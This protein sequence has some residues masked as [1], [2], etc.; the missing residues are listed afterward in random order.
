MLASLSTC[1]PVEVRVTDTYKVLTCDN[2][3]HLN[4][5]VN[6]QACRHTSV[7]IRLA[8]SIADAVLAILT[9]CDC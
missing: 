4:W 2:A 9:R 6:R 1:T 5:S 3:P 8:E 7:L